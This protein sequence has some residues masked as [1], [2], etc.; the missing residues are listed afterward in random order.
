[1]M[2]VGLIPPDSL[3]DRSAPIR[4]AVPLAYD[5]DAF[6]S[7]LTSH[8][9]WAAIVLRLTGSAV[10]GAGCLALAARSYRKAMNR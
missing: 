7:A 5:I 6:A 4:A 3:P 2:F 1:M 8:P 9:D 10:F